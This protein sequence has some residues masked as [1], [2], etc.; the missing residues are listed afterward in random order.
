M[1]TILEAAEAWMAITDKDSAEAVK[2]FLAYYE[3]VQAASKE[4]GRQARSQLSVR[5]K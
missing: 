3:A 1:K 5:N 2:A 4:E